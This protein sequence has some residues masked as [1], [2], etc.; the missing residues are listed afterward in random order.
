[1]ANVANDFSSWIANLP[2]W[3]GWLQLSPERAYMHA[4]EAYNDQYGVTVPDPAE[5]EGLCNLLKTHEIDNAGPALEIGCGTGFLTYGV[6]Q[7]YPGPDFLITDPSPTFLRITQ[8]QLEELPSGGA[9]RHFAIFNG[10]DLN[11]LPP[12]MFSVIALRSTLHHILRVEEFIAASARALRPNGA[13]LMGAEPYESG[14]LLMATVARFIPLAF[15]AAGVEMK[16]EWTRQLDDF[17]ATVQF[18]CLRDV[19]KSDAEDKHMF[20]AHEMAEMGSAHGLHL[21]FLPT[22]AF[23][24]QAAPFL[25]GFRG[26]SDFFFVYLRSCMRFDAEFQELVRQHLHDQL[27]YIDD[28]YRSHP[29]PAMTGVFIL[30]KTA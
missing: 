12:G 5:G 28:C 24:D 10:D 8:H 22:A 15:R 20:D 11:L 6:A 16:P 23:R 29:G 2:R 17:T 14:Y 18:S 19:D 1:M 7:H 26:F 3:R 13:L 9:R 4:E 25:R 30:K 21:R 27:T